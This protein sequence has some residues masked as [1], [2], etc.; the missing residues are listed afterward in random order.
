MSD[1]AV[2]AQSIID[3]IRANGPR[4]TYQSRVVRRIRDDF[5][6]EWSYKNHNGNWAIDKKILAALRPFKDESIHWDRGSQS[7]R[8]VDAAERAQLAER[9]AFLAARRVELARRRAEH[10]A[11]ET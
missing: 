4:R 10:A 6:E 5:G 1:A 3:E 2:I 9:E 7:W 11:T 8:V